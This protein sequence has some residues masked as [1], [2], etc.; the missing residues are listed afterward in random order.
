MKQALSALSR[1]ALTLAVLAIVAVV[2]RPVQGDEASADAVQCELNPPRDRAGLEACLARSPQDVELLLDLGEA[3]AAEG[4]AAEA[5][6]MYVR[7]AAIDPRDAEARR[8]L[9]DSR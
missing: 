7:A 6:D 8:R 5:R 9:D 3:Y 4:R 2:N 1:L